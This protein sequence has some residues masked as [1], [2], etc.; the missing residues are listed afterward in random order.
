GAI[1]TGVFGPRRGGRGRGGAGR[2][3]DR[4]ALLVLRAAQTAERRLAIGVSRERVLVQVDP[5]P[6]RGGQR[7]V[8]LLDR[9]RRPR[10]RPPHL[11]E[12]DEVLGDQEVRHAGG[13]GGRRGPPGGGAGG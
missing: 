6:G 4:A 8:A 11:L 9:E 7:D 5:E 3:G 13:G 1:W 10:D 2:P 12:V